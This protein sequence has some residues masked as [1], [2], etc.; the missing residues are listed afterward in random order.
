MPIV[1]CVKYDKEHCK[2]VSGGWWLRTE[3]ELS[4]GQRLVDYTASI[5]RFT[6]LAVS[7]PETELDDV[8]IRIVRSKDSMGAAFKFAYLS[9]CKSDRRKSMPDMVVGYS[10][11][12]VDLEKTIIHEALHLLN[13]DEQAVEQKT[14]WIAHKRSVGD[15]TVTRRKVVKRRSLYD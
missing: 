11:D 3:L 9:R 1:Q 5:L 14:H 15:S 4:L 7:K 13:Y 2:L 12:L 10:G 6:C 8:V